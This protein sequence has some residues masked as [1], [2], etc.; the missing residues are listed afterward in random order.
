MKNIKNTNQ[1]IVNISKTDSILVN[2]YSFR[3]S[4]T[5]YVN[6]IYVHAFLNFPYNWATWRLPKNLLKKECKISFFDTTKIIVT[7]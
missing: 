3:P 5:R 6:S 7:W 1:L 2:K 4:I